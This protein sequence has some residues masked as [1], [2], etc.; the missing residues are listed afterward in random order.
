M[1]AATDPRGP[2]LYFLPYVNGSTEQ[3]EARGAFIGLSS[4]HGVADMTRAVFEGVAFEHRYSVERLMGGA[5]LPATV[6]FAGG[7]AR[8]A[9][10]RGIF[11][12]VLGTTL[13]MP[14]TGEIGTLGAA[15][16]AA[17]AVNLHVSLERAVTSM[18]LPGPANV[19]DIELSR[20]VA[21]RY[22]NHRMLQTSLAPA[23]R[24]LQD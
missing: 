14:Q 23:W 20:I 19:C 3:P 10:W 13:V 4:W 6:R 11:A 21:T 12:A 17:C 15:V 5:A 16:V 18:C 8:S 1:V 2:G 24:R 9:P 7:A 22:A